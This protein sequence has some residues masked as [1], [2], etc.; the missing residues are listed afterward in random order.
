MVLLPALAAGGCGRGSELENRG[1]LIP[2]HGPPQKKGLLKVLEWSTAQ[3]KENVSNKSLLCQ[4]GF[5]AHI[6]LLRQN[7][8]SVQ[9]MSENICPEISVSRILVKYLNGAAS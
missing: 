5:I 4:K 6:F 9:S 3:Q 1:S 8:C 7:V 2:P